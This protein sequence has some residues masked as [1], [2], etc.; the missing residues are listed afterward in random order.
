MWGC[1]GSRV[2]LSVCGGEAWGWEGRETTFLLPFAQ[3]QGSQQLILTLSSNY[4]FNHFLSP[5]C[6]GQATIKPPQDYRIPAVV[7]LLLPFPSFSLYST[8]Q[9][10]T[11]S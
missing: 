6:R 5:F 2:L 10:Q 3:V 1:G 11:S 8:R 9:T 7:S 4:I